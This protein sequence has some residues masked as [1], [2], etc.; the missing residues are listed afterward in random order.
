MS[1]TGQQLILA[2][3]QVTQMIEQS[4]IMQGQL[5]VA[6]QGID[7]TKELFEIVERPIIVVQ[8]ASWWQGGGE[9]VRPVIH[10]INKGRTGAKRIQILIGFTQEDPAYLP[11][12]Y[13]R[14][15]LI[16]FIPSGDP[17]N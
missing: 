12:E 11:K 15:P 6:K 2:R 8:D 5:D 17:W 10:L 7:Q 16:P 4:Q 14:L 9:T 3:D 13:S 1:Q